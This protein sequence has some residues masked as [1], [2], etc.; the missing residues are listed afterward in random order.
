LWIIFN[1][2]ANW[3]ANEGLVQGDVV[4]LIMDNRPEYV[5]SWL[6]LAKIG[7]VTSLINTNLSGPPLAELL[8]KYISLY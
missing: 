7:V 3:A 6:G 2:V 1:L 4:G 5:I 8:L